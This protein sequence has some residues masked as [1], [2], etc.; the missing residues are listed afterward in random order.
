MD[1][2][3]QTNSESQSN[4]APINGENGG[5]ASPSYIPKAPP[6]LSKDQAGLYRG[7]ELLG[8]RLRFNVRA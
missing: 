8:W 1:N 3:T 6:V 5:V 4:V 7:F 2:D